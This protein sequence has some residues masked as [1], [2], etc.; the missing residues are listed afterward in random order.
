MMMPVV[1]PA[2]LPNVLNKPPLSP[3]I[4]LGDVSDTTGAGAKSRRRGE[5]SDLPK[6]K[7]MLHFVLP[8]VLDTAPA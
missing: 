5:Q 6:P 2:V 7:R 1:M 3:M 8:I 4:S